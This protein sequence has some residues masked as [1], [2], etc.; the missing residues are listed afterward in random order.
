[1]VTKLLLSVLLVGAPLALAAPLQQRVA[2]TVI[3]NGQQVHGVTV[4][5]NGAVQS[6]T[7]PDPQPYVAADQSSSGLACFEQATGTWLL[8]AAN[9]Y[10]EPPAYYPYDPAMSGYYGYPYPYGYYPY[11]YYGGPFFQ[12]GHGFGHGH[13]EPHE[14]GRFERHEDGHFEPHE[15]GHPGGSF[16]HGS[17]GHGGGGHEG[18]HGGGGHGGGRR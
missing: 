9:V 13:F 15:H 3:I 4:V 12:F 2:Q 18:G 7:C 17:F 16:G 5:Q 6:Y 11:S 14:R 1:M 10:N 8:Q